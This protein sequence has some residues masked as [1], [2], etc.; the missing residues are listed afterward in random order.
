MKDWITFVIPTAG[1]MTLGRT[2]DSLDYPGVRTLVV[3]DTHD[4]ADSAY[5]QISRDWHGNKCSE[6]MEF[7]G[8]VNCWGHPQREAG[9]RA[10]TTPWIGFSQDDDVLLPGAL[11]DIEHVIANQDVPWPLLFRVDTWQVGIVWRSKEL[12]PGNIDADCIVVPNEPARLGHWGM[13]VTGDYA[14]I[15][16]TVALWGGQVDWR[17][18]LIARGRPQRD[19]TG[20]R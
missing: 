6:W 14:F 18:E 9:M 19:A 13:E 7:D 1:K 3:A 11:A 15:R 12:R 4:E 5:L 8:G 16:E 20:W 10:A 2:L 17:P